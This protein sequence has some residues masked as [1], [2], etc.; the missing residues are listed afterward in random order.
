MYDR[1]ME[2]V[3][4]DVT[5]FVL[6]G[7]K[8]KRMGTDKAF[9]TL[10]GRTLL[11]R[12]VDLARSVCADVRIVGE[13]GKVSAFATVVE[14]VFRGCGPLGGIHAALRSSNTDLNLILAVDVPFLSAEFLQFMITKSRCGALVTVARTSGG[15]QPLCAVYRREFADLAEKSLRAGIYRI[16][17]LFFPATTL[18]IDEEELRTAGFSPELFRN[19]NTPEDLAGVGK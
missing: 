10:N 14:D 1:R 6:A 7:G 2:A 19:L 9:V 18:V 15:W 11:E 8:S 12:M 3:S 16:D 17:G 13:H 4:A 5:A